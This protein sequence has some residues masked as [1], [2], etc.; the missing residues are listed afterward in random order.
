MEGDVKVY[1]TE[2]VYF[3]KGNE[4]KIP[5]KVVSLDDFNKLKKE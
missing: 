2:G 1:N 4:Y 3:F 5:K